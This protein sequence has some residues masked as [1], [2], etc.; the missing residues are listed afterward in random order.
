MLTID[1]GIYYIS[2]FKILHFYE[3]DKV[4]NKLCLT[5]IKLHVPYMQAV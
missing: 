3:Y 1:F 5:I 4:M 2:M